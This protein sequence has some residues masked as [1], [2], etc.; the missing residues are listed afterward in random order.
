MLEACLP[1]G[2]N[3][4]VKTC[5][6][7]AIL[8]WFMGEQNESLH[9]AI[10]KVTLWLY[11]GRERK[12]IHEREQQ[13]PLSSHLFIKRYMAELELANKREEMLASHEITRRQ[14]R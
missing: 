6:N 4:I 10:I 3:S 1:F 2:G 13:L 7:K 8:S 9:E 11:G 12:I 14:R 5:V